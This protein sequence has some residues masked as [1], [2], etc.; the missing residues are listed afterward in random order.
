VKENKSSAANSGGRA[1]SI[2]PDG[3]IIPSTYHLR[4]AEFFWWGRLGRRQRHIGKGAPLGLTREILGR[5]PK[6]AFGRGL[7]SLLASDLYSWGEGIR[8]RKQ[9]KGGVWGSR[10]LE[11]KREGLPQDSFL[12]CNLRGDL[13]TTAFTG[14][15][16]RRLRRRQS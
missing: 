3:I 11:R 2:I 13:A 16:L 15:G 5:A 7:Y 14:R 12:I 10:L 9:T 1:S 4:T 6:S 8:K